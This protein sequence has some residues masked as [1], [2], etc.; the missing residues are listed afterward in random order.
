VFGE[1]VPLALV[2][3]ASPVSIIPAVVLI[4]Q[5]DRPRPTGLTFLVGWTAGLIATTAVFVQVPRLLDGL[6]QP[7][8]RWSAWVRI[9]AGAVLIAFAMRRWRPVTGQPPRL[10]RG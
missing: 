2:V 9:A 8:P 3:A 4:L 1:L 10:P 7:A 6:D 5:S